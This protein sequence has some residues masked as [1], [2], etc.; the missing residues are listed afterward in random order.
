MNIAIIGGGPAGFAAA[1]KASNN[2]NHVVILEKNSDVLKKLLLTGSGKCNY[3]NI[4][5]SINK[6]HSR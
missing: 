2:K 5:Q 6:Y 4:N 1:I 3:W